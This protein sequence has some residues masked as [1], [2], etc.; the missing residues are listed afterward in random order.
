[1]RQRA[2]SVTSRYGDTLFNTY[3]FVRGSA[4][5]CVSVCPRAY[6]PNHTRDLCQMFVHVTY[7]G[8]SVLLRRAKSGSRS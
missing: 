6:L 3:Y 4:S 7:R 1:M 2:S 5:V 8:G